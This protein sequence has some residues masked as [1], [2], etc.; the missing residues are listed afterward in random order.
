MIE[1]ATFLI[2]EV[3]HYNMPTL[4]AF[5]PHSEIRIPH[6]LVS[7]KLIIALTGGGIYN[8]NKTASGEIEG[9]SSGRTAGS[10]P[11][12]LGSNP[13]PPAKGYC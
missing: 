1:S 12:K 4:R 13:N 8:Y 9:S 5:I 7:F 11:A 6:F 3:K 2:W 10:G